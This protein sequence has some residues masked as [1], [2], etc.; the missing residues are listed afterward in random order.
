MATNLGN[1]AK[2]F[3]TML[4]TRPEARSELVYAVTGDSA[5]RVWTLQELAILHELQ[6]PVTVLVY[7]LFDSSHRHV[8]GTLFSV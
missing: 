7:G 1:L 4:S 8:S 5:D 3:T 6:V 2:G